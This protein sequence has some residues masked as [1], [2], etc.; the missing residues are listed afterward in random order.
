M[1][2]PA[3]WHGWPE[4]N[5]LDRKKPKAPGR[6]TKARDVVIFSTPLPG[7]AAARALNNH[8]C[9]PSGEVL[10][11]AAFGLQRIAA[12]KR[13]FGRGAQLSRRGAP[14]TIIR[15][16]RMVDTGVRAGPKSFLVGRKVLGPGKKKKKKKTKK[17]KRLKG[18]TL[19]PVP[20]TP[21]SPSAGTCVNG[22]VRY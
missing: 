11:Q 12:A 10:F 2:A 17:K 20:K 8:S 5:G 15:Q 16:P 4:K 1:R 19:K 7:W 14:L 21:L 13:I 6:S 9:P 18:K 22:D 3:R